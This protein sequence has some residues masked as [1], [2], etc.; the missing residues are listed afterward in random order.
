MD[1][2]D[3]N[4]SYGNWKKIGSNVDRVLFCLGKMNEFFSIDIGK[5][6]RWVLTGKYS[7]IQMVT[8][9]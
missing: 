9:V 1:R 3:T 6:D 5:A 2:R 8:R 7:K 4:H